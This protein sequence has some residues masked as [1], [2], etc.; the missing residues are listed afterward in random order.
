MF[1]LLKVNRML[2]FPQQKCH[3]SCV[4]SMLDRRRV[5]VQSVGVG[6]TTRITWVSAK[7]YKLGE[8]STLGELS[9]KAKSFHQK[10]KTIKKRTVATVYANLAIF[11]SLSHSTDMYISGNKKRKE[12]KQIIFLY[13][14]VVSLSLL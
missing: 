11:H 9:R 1:L 14:S 6:V 10:K 12:K 2:V 3:V 8:I 4:G 7:L 5:Y 13:I